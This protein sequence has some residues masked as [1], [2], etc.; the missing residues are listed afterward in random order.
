MENW[1]LVTF[2]EAVL[3]LEDTATTYQRQRVCVLITHELAHQCRC[4]ERTKD[5]LAVTH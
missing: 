1:G 3:L 2:E 5:V 4:A